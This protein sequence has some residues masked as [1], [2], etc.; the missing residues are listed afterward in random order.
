MTCIV[1]IPALVH[2]SQK[3]TSKLP[4]GVYGSAVRG[5]MGLFY[6]RF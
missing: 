1:G 6:S 5:K 2:N 4:V 3:S